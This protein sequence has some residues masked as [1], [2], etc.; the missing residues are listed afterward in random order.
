MKLY[1][2]PKKIRRK[3]GSLGFLRSSWKR[4]EHFYFSLRKSKEYVNSLKVFLSRNH[5]L[6]LSL[7]KPTIFHGK[8]NVF[9]F[10]YR[11]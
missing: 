1:Y 3:L 8:S 2:K 9:A 7:E 5:I 6:K 4:L 11:K 10:Q